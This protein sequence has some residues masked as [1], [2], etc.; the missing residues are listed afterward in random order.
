MMQS[1]TRVPKDHLL[2]GPER[3]PR[4]HWSASIKPTICELQSIFPTHV[5]GRGFLITDYIGD[6]AEL[7]EGPLCP[8][9]RVP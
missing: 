7:P 6:F 3:L 4:P 2:L 5:N 1:G 9:S 8:L